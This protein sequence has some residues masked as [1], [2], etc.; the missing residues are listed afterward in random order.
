LLFRRISI[1]GLLMLVALI[2]MVV[3]MFVVV[4]GCGSSE[5]TATIVPTVPA[6]GVVTYQGKPL[7]GHRITF[8]PVGDERPAS[9]V[10]DDQGRFVLGTNGE[11]DGA[12]VGIHKVTIVP[13]SLAGTVEP[14]KEVP[15]MMPV[16]P[17]PLPPKYSDVKTSELTVTIPEGG[18]REI[19]VKLE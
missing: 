11:D 10:T 9:G 16:P 19:E 12:V 18:T 4:C 3:S 8:Y 17:S 15:G 7:A 6:S 2:A 14:G 13:E 1:A 5:P